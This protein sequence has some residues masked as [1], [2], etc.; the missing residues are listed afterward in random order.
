MLER[1]SQ[2]K[3]RSFSS[4]EKD[5]VRTGI[6]LSLYMGI[7]LG[8]ICASE[9]KACSF[10][11]KGS[12]GSMPRC[13]GYRQQKRRKVRKRRSSLQNRKVFTRSGKFR[14]LRFFWNIWNIWGVTRKKHIYWLVRKPVLWNRETCKTISGISGG[15]S[16]PAGEFPCTSSYLC[17]PLH[18]ERCGHQSIEWDPRPCKRQYY[19]EPVCSFLSGDE[20]AKHGEGPAFVQVWQSDRRSVSNIDRFAEKIQWWWKKTEKPKIGSWQVRKRMLILGK[21][22]FK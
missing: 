17:H 3:I 14:S 15:L 22:I 4:W 18:R 21:I 8:E 2:N 19:I 1:Q 6:L 11:R 10:M 16:A 7:R 13:S 20:K 5:P 12:S 9:A